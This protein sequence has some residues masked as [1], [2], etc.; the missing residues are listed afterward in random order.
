MELKKKTIIWEE[1]TEPPKNYYWIKPDNKV[2]EWDADLEDWM[3]SK[4]FSYV[5]SSINAKGF[6][7]NEPTEELSSAISSYD[8][9]NP[10]KPTSTITLN[11]ESVP[12]T[13][14]IPETSHPVTLKGDFS[15]N[16][17]TI[18]SAGDVEK[19]TVNNTGDEA[20]LVINLPSSTVTLSGQYNEV[21]VEAV[22]NNTLI[23]NASTHINKL[24]LKKGTVLVKNAY[25]SDN[26][27]EVVTKYGKVSANPVYT[28][29]TG[30]T[31]IISTPRIVNFA[32]DL[33]FG[34]TVF[35]VLA[36]GHYV[37]DPKGHKINFTKTGVLLKGLVVTL[38]FIGDGEWHSTSNPLIWNSDAES[39][40][41][42]YGGK[43]FAGNSNECIYAEKGNIE[44][45]DGEFHNVPEEGK[46]NFLI[47]CFDANYKNGTA[48]IK[49]Y[50]GKFYG[51]DPAANAAESTDMTTNFVADGYKSVYN[52]DGNFYEVIKK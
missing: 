47:N 35:G 25:V 14:T 28:A 39:V 11:M 21:L 4:E 18:E 19:V 51:F 33:T 2:Y 3:E 15:N 34:N 30:S 36:N 29:K 50:G 16:K 37:F 38:D 9:A 13:I 45:Y 44:I 5:P 24:I 10:T 7:T 8:E 41:R 43:F 12:E 23:V 27:D 48:N 40:I 20:D 6:S 46:K 49:I 32:E 52:K 42:I 31:A 17:T 26:I 1:N 22:S